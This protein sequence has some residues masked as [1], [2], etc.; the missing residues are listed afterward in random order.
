MSD[1]ATVRRVAEHFV[2]RPTIVAPLAQGHI[3]ETYAVA[4]DDGGIVVQRVNQTIFTDVTGMTANAVTVAR[5]L[6]G[7][8]VP[9]PRAT[10]DGEWLVYEGDDVWRA[11]GRVAGAAPA[12]STTVDAVRAAGALLGRFHTLVA[13]LDAGALVET[14]PRFHDPRRRLDALRG[15]VAADTYGRAAGVG[16]EI[17][18]A[19]AAR[20]LVDVA[21][22]L[23]GRVPVR[24]AHND[25][26]LDNFLFRGAKAVALVDLD[27]LMP[28]AWFWDAGDLLRSASTTAAEDDANTT[29]DEACSDAAM[30]GYRLAV[31]DGVL[32]I[33]EREALGAAA[34][35]ATYE[36]GVRFLT[37]W[38]EGDVYYRTTRTAQNR[39]RA[40]AQFRLLCAMPGPHRSA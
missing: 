35:I 25:P 38:L 39:D 34:A 2:T 14:L 33:D 19:F 7:Q 36:Q 26:K 20:V 27:T 17:D 4:S 13:D 22:E 15:A 40:R 18:T 21:D 30:A 6:R 8:I 5:H 24:V 9:E 28:G 12:A 1:D 29:F 11:F 10:R 37:D 3:N 16:D 31:P 23:A 32:T